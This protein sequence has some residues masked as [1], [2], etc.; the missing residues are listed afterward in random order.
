MTSHSSDPTAD[1]LTIREK[2][3]ALAARRGVD[4][5]TLKDADVIPD[6]GALDSMAILELIMWF[7]TTFDLTI[8]QSELTVE[9]FGSIDAIAN[10]LQRAGSAATG[11]GPDIES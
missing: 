6:S 3:I 4:A 5:R 10:Y 1:R 2:V 8:E 11:D 7:E 9:N